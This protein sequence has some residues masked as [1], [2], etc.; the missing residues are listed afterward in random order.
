MPTAAECY[1]EISKL[2]EGVQNRKFLHPTEYRSYIV[3]EQVDRELADLR[4]LRK[5]LSRTP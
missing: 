5:S 2:I 3:N 4:R 1:K